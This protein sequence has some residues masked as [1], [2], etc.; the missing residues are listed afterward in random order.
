MPYITNERREDFDHALALL[1][2]NMKCIIGGIQKGDV[3][4]VISQIVIE[5][6]KLKG[7]SYGTCS[8]VTGLLND[9]KIEFER[10][11][12]APYEDKKIKENG[13]IYNRLDKSPGKTY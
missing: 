11:V 4:Y 3:N 8:D 10:R 12:V 5:Y 6:C 7:I 9:V 13:D 1:F 2:D